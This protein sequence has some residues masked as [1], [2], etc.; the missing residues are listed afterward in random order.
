MQWKILGHIQCFTETHGYPPTLRELALLCDRGATVVLY[1][2][3]ALEKMG[4]ITR[5]AKVARSIR[6]VAK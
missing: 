1:H 4:V 2:L 5:D 3:R 6:I